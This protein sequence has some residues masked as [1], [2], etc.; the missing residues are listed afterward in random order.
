MTFLR[1]VLLALAALVLCT[2]AAFAHASLL[3]SDPPDGALIDA[4]PP[5]LTLTFNEPVRPLVARLTQADGETQML[6]PP[7]VE[8]LSLIYP[9]P[10]ATG[11]G[12]QLFS[13]RVTSED[14]HPLAGGT[15]FSVGTETA[16]T[17][18]SGAAAPALTRALVW[19]ARAGLVLSVLLAVGGAAFRALVGRDPSA[20][21]RRAAAVGL[22]LL[23]LVLGAQGL[24]LLGL[25][26]SG[27]FGA[28]P[29][30]EGAAGAP[31]LA[32]LLT[33]AALCAVWLRAPWGLAVLLAGLGAATSGH[34]ATAAPRLFM[35]PA[36][37]IHVIA[38]ALW[39]GALWPLARSLPD[40]APLRRFGAVIPWVLAALIASGSAI[41]LVQLRHLPALWQ[42]DYGRV[43][44]AKLGLVGG[45][46]LVAL[47]NRL[48]LTGR[49]EAGAP[50]PL[51]R[52]IVV[53]LALAV[54]IV[55]TLALWRFTPPPRSLT[56]PLPDL[57][58][59]VAAE[60][61]SATL[62]VAP[63]RQG[64]VRLWL[65]GL[66]LDGEAVVPQAV[67]V[68]LA[69]PAYGIGPFRRELPG[70]A[71]EIA[72]GTFLLPLDGYWVLTLNV[73]V[74]DFRAIRLRDIVEIAPA[75]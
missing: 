23:P 67:E 29:W 21:P 12:T 57:I 70:T 35:R 39:I 27:L 28:A 26:P 9:L 73:R 20:L 43:M 72:L 32:L 11:Q 46:L 33:G 56:P 64:P 8:G 75:R 58:Q 52:A 22:L 71:G 74:S 48:R 25:P 2:G 18:E 44:L 59:P 40:P 51:R 53:E 37:A 61:L 3:S 17:G 65:D 30:R 13:W 31:G 49:A 36:V 47:V 7:R 41:M 63:P 50:G 68:E 6:D 4:A 10:P 54:L 62:R 45:L 14:G 24:D 60:G 19:A 42:T 15:L 5:T 34:A 66:R 1:R 69:K 38:A 55:G 16:M